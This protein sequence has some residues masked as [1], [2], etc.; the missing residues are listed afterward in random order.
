MSMTIVCVPSGVFL[1][2]FLRFLF[3]F[4]CEFSVPRRPGSIG[5]RGG[6]F[7]C[8]VSRRDGNRRS[9]LKCRINLQKVEVLHVKMKKT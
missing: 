2:V 5:R 4:V 7:L 9:V 3:E 6:A 1:Y 8:P